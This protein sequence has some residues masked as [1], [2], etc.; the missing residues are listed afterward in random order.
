MRAALLNLLSHSIAASWIKSE[1]P[2]VAIADLSTAA[3]QTS[4]DK[5]HKSAHPAAAGGGLTPL[6]PVVS[7]TESSTDGGPIMLRADGQPAEHYAPQETAELEAHNRL[8]WER[9]HSVA[10]PWELATDDDTWTCVVWGY[11]SDTVEVDTLGLELRGPARRF[12]AVLP[13][14]PSWCRLRMLLQC[15]NSAGG[16]RLNVELHSRSL[17]PGV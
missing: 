17:G 8:I 7:A 14:V 1:Q 15:S 4:Q 10:L 16:Q 3:S 11:H 5:K 6:P 13:E 12:C 9:E 2:E